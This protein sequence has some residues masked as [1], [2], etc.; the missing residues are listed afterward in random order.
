M[1]LAIITARQGSKRIKNKNLKKID[2]KYLIEIVINNILRTKIFDK[3]IVSTDSKKI[4]A[5]V[6]KINKKVEVPFLRP[7]KLSGDFTGTREVVLHAINFFENK[8]L[9]IENVCCFYPTSIFF[10]T[11]NLIKALNNL[12]SKNYIISSKKINA[13]FN[14]SFLIKKEKIKSFIAK[15]NIKKRSQ[16]FKDLYIDAAQFYLAKKNTWL[17]K[18]NIIEPGTKIILLPTYNSVDIDTEEDLF[19]AKKLFK[20]LN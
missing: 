20:S 18:K 10:E 9:N 2:K 16:D 3:I 19:F 6:K 17:S 11:K 5:L 14:R 4:S 7:K 15:K 1:N 8:D 13:N 12:D